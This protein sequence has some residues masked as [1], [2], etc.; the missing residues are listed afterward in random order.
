MIHDQLIL[1]TMYIEVFTFHAH[2]YGFKEHKFSIFLFIV[3]FAM[4]NNYM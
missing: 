2:S 4:T 1:H 3:Y